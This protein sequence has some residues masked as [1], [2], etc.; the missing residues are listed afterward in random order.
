M[1]HAYRSESVPAVKMMVRSVPLLKAPLSFAI[2]FRRALGSTSSS[3]L[4]SH[5]ILAKPWSLLMNHLRLNSASCIPGQ[6]T[7]LSNGYGIRSRDGLHRTCLLTFPL[8]FMLMMSSIRCTS[9]HRPGGG[10]ESKALNFLQT[11][12][13]AHFS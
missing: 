3:S 5:M 6:A 10:F 2:R 12:C 1:L 13:I 4:V 7:G 8:F 11:S 9:P